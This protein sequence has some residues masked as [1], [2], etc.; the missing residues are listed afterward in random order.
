MSIYFRYI[1]KKL[2]LSMLIVTPIVSGVLWMTLSLRYVNLVIS[3][4]LSL[5]TYLYLI[6]CVLPDISSVIMPLCFLISGI[7]VLYKLQS[8]KEIIIFKGVGKSNYALASPLIT[9]SFILAA[10]TFFLQTVI[11]PEAYRSL[12]KIQTEIQKQITPSFLKEGVFNVIGS[13]IVYIGTKKQNSLETIFISYSNP[14]QNENTIITA[15]KGQFLISEDTLFIKLENGVKQTVK[16]SKNETSTLNFKNLTYDAT[17]FIKSLKPKI[18]KLCEKTQQEL[19]ELAYNTN[20]YQEKLKILAEANL[21]IT[22]PLLCIINALLLSFFLITEKLKHRKKA[23]AKCFSCGVSSQILTIIMTNLISTDKNFIIYT[24]SMI[25][26]II[27][28]LSLK[29]FVFTNQKKS[30]P[31]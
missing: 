23:V 1:L 7:Q 8:D 5:V 4:D 13:T 31:L 11:S 17:P 25:I 9:L 21:R 27:T 3:N 26:I 30:S 2:I 24:Y 14:S 16:K 20:S 10:L 22:T 6:L 19:F 12:R 15:R 18:E 29:N 28:A